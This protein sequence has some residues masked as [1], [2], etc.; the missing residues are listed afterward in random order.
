M[1][2]VP[3]SPE[4]AISKWQVPWSGNNWADPRTNYAYRLGGTGVGK[5]NHNVPPGLPTG[6]PTG[7]P[8]PNL[9][10][11]EYFRL[12]KG[13]TITISGSFVTPLTA[14]NFATNAGQFLTVGLVNKPWV[15]YATLTFGY[16]SG[17]FNTPGVGANGNAYLL[18]FKN[19]SNV[20]AAMEDHNSG[21]VTSPDQRDVASVTAFSIQF[22]DGLD[23]TGATGRHGRPHALLAGG[24]CLWTVGRQ[25]PRLPPA[26]GSATRCPHG[27]RRRLPAR[28]SSRSR[29]PSAISGTTW[30]SPRTAVATCRQSPT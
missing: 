14:A 5:N 3:H 2:S 13:G 21:N 23:K 4:P 24:R 8:D 7:T 27:G 20:R 10:S 22:Q 16:N 6:F 15:D 17:M 11:I 28:I 19:G 30:P 1:N 9:A 29:P 18:F 26:H 25:Q 12:P